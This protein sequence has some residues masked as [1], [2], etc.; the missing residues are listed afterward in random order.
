MDAEASY[1]LLKNKTTKKNNRKKKPLTPKVIFFLL[2]YSNHRLQ[3]QNAVIRKFSLEKRPINSHGCEQRAFPAWEKCHV[4][5]PVRYSSFPFCIAQ[6]KKT[7]KVKFASPSSFDHMVSRKIPVHFPLPLRHSRP[8]SGHRGGA[9]CAV[10]V[11]GR[12][13][14]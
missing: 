6:I 14:P 13:L 3:E 2:S 5:D 7:A 11:P 4:Q 8:D 12:A 9:S 10:W 1:L